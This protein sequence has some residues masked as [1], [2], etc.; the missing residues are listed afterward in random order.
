ML[1]ITLPTAA[2]PPKPPSI[3]TVVE[4]HSYSVVDEP[5][6]DGLRER[7]LGRLHEL[8]PE[9][10][11][12]GI[13]AERIL[14]REDCPLFSPGAYADR[15]TVTTPVEGLMLAGDGIRIDLPVALME[16]AATTGWSAANRLLAGWGI[17]GHTLHTVPVQ[18]RSPVLRR[19][20]TR[21][22][23]ALR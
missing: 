11:Q 18:G 17:S 7:M 21:E 22:G 2:G 19:L 20:A 12:A 9:T 14:F 6:F 3:S 13:V 15:P 8:Y 16:R 23:R 4:V 10:A 1:L 5:P